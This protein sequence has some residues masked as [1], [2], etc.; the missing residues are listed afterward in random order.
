MAIIGLSGY[1]IVSCERN[2][3]AEKLADRLIDKSA[4]KGCFVESYP[5]DP[6]NSLYGVKYR[7]VMVRNKSQDTHVAGF[8]WFEDA[9][10]AMDKI[11][12]CKK[13]K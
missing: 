7:I 1:G 3:R 13:T 6:T 9:R 11:E 10:V 5:V 8:Y 12:E 4:V 2:E